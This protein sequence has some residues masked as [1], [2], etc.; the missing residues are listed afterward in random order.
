MNEAA[1]G[2][3]PSSQ[4]LGNFAEQKQGGGDLFRSVQVIDET[5]RAFAAEFHDL[6]MSVSTNE[7][8]RIGASD[9]AH[10]HCTKE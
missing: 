10:P 3:A 2:I 5:V 7:A 6:D 9:P 8:S 1:R 4:R